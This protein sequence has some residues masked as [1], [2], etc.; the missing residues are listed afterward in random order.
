M[1]THLLERILNI[2]RHMAAT[3]M[4]NPLLDYVMDEAIRLVGAERG[5]VVL[6][7]ADGALD[8]RIKR[9][10][11]G[12]ELKNAEDQV[13]KSILNKVIQTGEPLILSDAMTDARFERSRSV[14]LLKLRSIM[15]VPLT[16]SGDTIG[17]I[18][19]ENRSILDRFDDND[20]S[21]LIL[22]ANQA[23]V[24]I[25]NAKLNDNLEA[26]IA[27]RT[28]ELK[29]VMAQ[30]EENL[31]ETVE[32]NRIRTVWMNNVIHDLRTGVTVVSGAMTL[33]RMP[34]FGN[35]SHKQ[36]ETLDKASDAVEYTL[37]LIGDLLDFS[38][39]EA[40]RLALYLEVV[41]LPEFLESVHEAGLRLP[42][43][44]TV[45]FKL[46]IPAHL[47]DLSIDPLRIRQVLLNLLSNARKFT[48]EGT[49]TLYARH[50]VE[51]DQILFGVSDTG[52]GI[53]E[54]KISRLFERFFQRRDDDRER[55]GM[56]SGLGL[57]ISQALVQLHSGHIWAESSP[58][59]GSNFMFTLPL[60]PPTPKSEDTA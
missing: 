59:V 36:I 16:V 37:K 44:E 27:D 53:P 7:Q 19:V 23:A 29:Q 3:R 26:R 14:A 39:L 56:G 40:G 28:D 8:F 33:L 10:Q 11:S 22:F 45:T 41:V 12:R 46:D 38:K 24:S 4:L 2:S 50:R 6:L 60:N 31:A 54:D 20:L 58:G 25:E 30:I 48:P 17:A 32:N 13:S 5:F 9:D 18:Y 15:C 42:W 21:P 49:V 35:L 34:A 52:E 47:P 55:Q 1:D 43:P 51:E 57:A